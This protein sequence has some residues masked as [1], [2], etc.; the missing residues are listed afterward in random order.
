MFCKFCAS[1]G[2]FISGFACV[3]SHCWIVTSLN[4]VVWVTSQ[5]LRGTNK[6]LKFFNFWLWIVT[7]YTADIRSSKYWYLVGIWSQRYFHMCRHICVFKPHRDG[8]A[9]A[10]AVLYKY[11]MGNRIGVIC[12][13][14][15]E[16]VSSPLSQIW[17]LVEGTLGIWVAELFNRCP[18]LFILGLIYQPW[19]LNRVLP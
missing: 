5:I 16:L 7:K 19:D 13:S 11:L 14:A 1:F 6:W 15:V 3:Y 10:I 9:R 8:C 4:C 2:L 17:H 18:S 12:R